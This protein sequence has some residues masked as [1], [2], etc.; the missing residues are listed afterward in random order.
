MLKCSSLQLIV[1]GRGVSGRSHKDQGVDLG[2]LG[3]MM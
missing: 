3:C 2:G 1:S